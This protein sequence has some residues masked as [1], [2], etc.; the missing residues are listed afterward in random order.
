M[1]SAKPGSSLGLNRV[2]INLM[3]VAAFTFNH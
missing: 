2:Y 3:Q 1:P